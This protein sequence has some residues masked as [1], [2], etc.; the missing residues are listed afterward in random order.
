MK[1]VVSI[2]SLVAFTMCVTTF[3]SYAQKPT[4]SKL[5]KK[6]SNKIVYPYLS[7]ENM[8]GEV[9]ISFYIKPNGKIDVMSIDSSND[10]LI[11][12]VLRRMSKIE[13]PLDDSKIGTTQSMKLNFKKEGKDSI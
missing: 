4:E 9:S 2:L 6:I 1:K 12:Y 10:K 5:E 13:L 3:P 11:S 7:Q 8:E